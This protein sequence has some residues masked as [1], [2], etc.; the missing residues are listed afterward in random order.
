MIS[1]GAVVTT[2]VRIGRSAILNT[3]CV[4]D[5]DSVVR[6]WAHVGPGAVVGADADIGEQALIGL[7][8]LVMSGRRVGARTTVGAGAVV[9]RDLPDDVIAIGVPARVTRH[10]RPA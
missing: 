5:H 1:A 8:A 6:E 2:G 9:V 10:C 4:V 3:R 7:G